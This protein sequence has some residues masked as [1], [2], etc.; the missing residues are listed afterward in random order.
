MI[1]RK[2]QHGDTCGFHARELDRQRLMAGAFAIECQI[3][4]ENERV[5]MPG[6]D[7]RDESLNKLLAVRHDLAV[8]ALDHLRKARSVVG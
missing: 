7:L 3:A 2:H 8:A 5:R 6:D 4:R 1:A